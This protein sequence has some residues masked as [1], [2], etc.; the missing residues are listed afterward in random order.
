MKKI[1]IEGHEET[2]HH[3]HAMVAAAV[4]ALAGC[5]SS[6]SSSSS[7][8]SASTS[9]TKTSKFVLGGLWPET[10]SL[11]YLAPPELAAE[12]LAVKDINDA[13]GVLGNK[14]TTVDADTSDADHADQNT[15]AAPIRPQQEPVVHH[16][17]GLQLRGQEHLQV[18][19]LAKHSDAVD[20]RHL[21]RLLRP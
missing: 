14:I 4:M 5:G 3:S 19:H 12:K 10:G 8:S 9:G 16:R 11:A 7:S 6:N 17:P 15:S 13:G 21:G 20:G 1:N 18:H 2:V